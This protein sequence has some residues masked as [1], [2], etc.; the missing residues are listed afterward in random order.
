MLNHFQC[1]LGEAG[2]ELRIVIG[3]EDFRV[4]EELGIGVDGRS[5]GRHVQVI[6]GDAFLQRVADDL[7][8]ELDLF[9]PHLDRLILVLEDEVDG[10]DD[11]RDQ[12]L[13]QF[14][15][16]GDEIFARIDAVADVMTGLDRQNLL[17]LDQDLGMAR[18]QCVGDVRVPGNPGV[19]A[20]V[21]QQGRHVRSL[22]LE[23]FHVADLQAD[24]GQRLDQQRILLRSLA[25]KGNALALQFLHG[26]DR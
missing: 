25:R 5:L 3:L 4:L 12:I 11:G 9:G 13:N 1:L 20:F 24:I 7:F 15:P 17:S 10:L 22:G 19:D 16:G 18:R 23:Q 21:R 8:R 2:I 6:D 26:R 14:R